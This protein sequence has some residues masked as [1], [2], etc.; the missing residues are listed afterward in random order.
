MTLPTKAARAP[1]PATPTMVLAAEPPDILDRR[2]HR[3]VDRLRARLVDQRHAA[4]VHALRDEEVVLGAG[5]HIDDGV[6]DAENVVAVGC[7]ADTH[8]VLRRAL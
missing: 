5:D 7:H 1:K 4:L 6:A 2:A 3:V 8:E